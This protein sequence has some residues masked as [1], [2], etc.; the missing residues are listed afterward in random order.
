M[1]AISLGW[2]V[3][4]WTLAA[5]AALGEL[6]A[7]VA[8]HSDTFWEKA[9]TYAFIKTWQPWLIEHGLR[10]V[11]V[12]EPSQAVE[13]VNT[14]WTDIPAFTATERSDGQ[15]RR[16]CTNHWKIVPIRRWLT[17]ELTR[18][19][20]KKAPGVVESLQGISLD[21]FHRMRTSDVRWIVNRYP[22][23]E[24]RMTRGDCIAWL[25]THDLPTPPKSA[26]VFCPFQSKRAWQELKRVGG[27]D[28]ETAVRI[29]SEIRSVRP[30]H[31][32]FVHPARVPLPQA[33]T[34]VE[35]YGM[36]Q[37]SLLD[38]A[39]GCDSGYCFV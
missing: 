36:E 39:A 19:G 11:T 27:S 17:K 13:K 4:S 34:L 25:A 7:D 23:V 37:A 3:Q 18:Q 20:V 6:D 32:L 8:I 14:Q 12:G 33:I 5:M 21:E 2:G 24:M 9:E 30:P 38:D 16:Q 26:C 35:D 29:D 1:K 10:V 22:L 31:D 15:L 28:W